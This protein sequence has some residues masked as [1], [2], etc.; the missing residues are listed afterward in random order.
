LHYDLQ[1]TV[2]DPSNRIAVTFVVSI[3]FRNGKRWANFP[4]LA[5]QSRVFIAGRIFGITTDVTQL[6][7]LV[8]D[9]YFIP[10]VSSIVTTPST[11][12]SSTGKR[13]QADRWSSR[14]TPSTPIRKLRILGSV[15]GSQNLAEGHQ[16][17]EGSL[18]SATVTSSDALTPTESQCF[19][20]AFTKDTEP[21]LSTHLEDRS[22]TTA[23]VVD[24]SGTVKN[25]VQILTCDAWVA[26]SAIRIS[27]I[28]F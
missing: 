22:D 11:P 1:T 5:M 2:Y 3:Y 19:S 9:V 14:A 21:D 13:K 28:S 26:P 20:E 8:D 15:A 4:T 23:R 24:H 27:I 10:N 6:A 12:A 17:H 18:T 25:P 16:T 7:I